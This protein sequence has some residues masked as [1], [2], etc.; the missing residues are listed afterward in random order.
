MF[1]AILGA[2]RRDRVR[3]ITVLHASVVVLE[4]LSRLETKTKTIFCCLGL[5]FVSPSNCLGLVS[6]SLSSDFICL[7]VSSRSRPQS[8]LFSSRISEQMS[9]VSST[10]ETSRDKTMQRVHYKDRGADKNSL[11]LP[12]SGLG[13]GL[14]L[15]STR[16]WS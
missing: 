4:T 9:R 12:R 11:L 16:S 3:D 10:T 1:H 6:V 15:D 7:V 5:V 13:L 14:D 2:K 8:V